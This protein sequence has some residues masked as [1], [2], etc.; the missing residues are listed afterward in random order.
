MPRSSLPGTLPSPGPV[1]RRSLL[2]RHVSTG[3]T[4]SIED[5]KISPQVALPSNSAMFETSPRVPTELLDHTIALFI[6]SFCLPVS[7]RNTAFVLIKPLTLVS[8]DFRHLVLR[9]Y[10][11]ILVL[12]NKSSIGLFRFLRD[13]DAVNRQRGFTWVRSV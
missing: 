13:E 5:K 4:T 1:R 2:T 8:K 10:F 7:I 3:S 6:A 9:H 12:Q 11:A